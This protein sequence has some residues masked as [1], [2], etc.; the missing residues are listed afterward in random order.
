MIFF[1]WV[2]NAGV[3][4]ADQVQF[5]PG[6]PSNEGLIPTV[7]SVTVEHKD[8][9]M[10]VD[11]DQGGLADL[12]SNMCTTGG[13]HRTLYKGEMNQEGGDTGRL[14]GQGVFVVAM[15]SEGNKAAAT[16]AM[17]AAL[18]LNKKDFAQRFPHIDMVVKKASG[19]GLHT[20]RG[21][22]GYV[23]KECYRPT[24]KTICT[25][26]ITDVDYE[27]GK[28]LQARFGAVFK[29]M[30]ELTPYNVMKKMLTFYQ[31]HHTMENVP[32]DVSFIDTL[33]KMFKTGGYQASVQFVIRNYGTGV[34]EERADALLQLNLLR[35][36]G[37]TDTQLEQ[38]IRSVFIAPRQPYGRRNLPVFSQARR[39]EEQ[40]IVRT[41]DVMAM[42]DDVRIDTTPDS[43]TSHITVRPDYDAAASERCRQHEA[44][45]QQLQ[46]FE[47]QMPSRSSTVVEL[48]Y[49]GGE[50]TTIGAGAAAIE[51]HEVQSR[52]RDSTT[53][54]SGNVD[55]NDCDPLE[56]HMVQ[57]AKLG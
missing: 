29:E 4:I 5:V 11:W 2:T 46:L 22:V 45:V 56:E 28:K 16:I 39:D 23:N 41:D 51:K 38:Q 57:L 15:S 17:Y 10:D 49:A 8:K 14:H 35:G 36:E 6:R 40:G 3:P 19:K 9:G 30:V 52:W 18:G 42:A 43:A 44:Q 33:K 27:E 1:F 53:A 7:I 48:Q 20:F 24:F 26:G 50:T 55:L 47:Q 37:L 54:F 31:L 34:D 21:L 32:H 13:V 12:F 25:L